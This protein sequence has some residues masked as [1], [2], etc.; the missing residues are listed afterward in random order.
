MK[1]IFYLVTTLIELNE[2]NIVDG[3]HLYANLKDAERAF[4]FELG[5]C[6]E[7]F[8]GQV[9]NLLIDLPHCREWRNDDGYGYTVTLEEIQPK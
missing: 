4:K 7:S 3:H 2:C 6:R 8:E 1:P 9:G 5:G